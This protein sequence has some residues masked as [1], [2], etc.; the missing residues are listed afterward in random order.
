LIKPILFILNKDEDMYYRLCKQLLESSLPQ[1]CELQMV[2]SAGTV[3]WAQLSATLLQEKDDNPVILMT[4]SDI[5]ERK[6][7]EKALAESEEKYRIIFN[8]EIYAICIFDVETYRF[9]DINHAFC[10]LYGYSREKLLSGMTIHDI[11]AEQ[12]AS[13]S[14]TQHSLSE[15]TVFIPIRYHRKKDG[16]IIPVEI[17][18]GP[19]SWKGKKVMFGLIHD[20][21]HRVKTEEQLKDSK[22]FNLAILNSLSAEIA[23]LDANGEITAVNQAWQGFALENSFEPGIPVAH[24]EIGT[25]YLKICRQVNGEEKVDALK[26]INGIESVLEGSLLSFCMEYPCHSQDKDRWFSMS[27][28]PLN[29]KTRGV[30]VVHTDITEQKQAESA[31]IKAQAEL[32]RRVLERTAELEETNATLVM[33]LDYARKA[34]IDIE[35]RVVA[36][37]RINNLQ[38][39]DGLKKQQL[40]DSALDIVELLGENIQNLAHPLTRKLDSLFLRLTPREMQIANFIR[41]GKTSKDIM[42]LLGLSFHTLESHRNNLRKKLGLRH[43]KVNLRAYLS[44]QFE[45]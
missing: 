36:N 6:L 43:K 21:S 22:V 18:G 38:L 10:L 7:V 27:V 3:F 17:V 23:V 20:I 14:S 24:T 32:E 44:S 16:T 2:R 30:V 34:E 31:L 5:T 12:Q 39:L 8:N 33:M 15:G 25:N 19:Y 9:L 42:Q 41:Q 28:T 11:T 37:L 26:A 35:E 1:S 40:S 4:L 45:K 13:E 29:S